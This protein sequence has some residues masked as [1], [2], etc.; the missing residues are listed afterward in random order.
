V[1]TVPGTGV[2]RTGNEEYLRLINALFCL[3][4]EAIS[5]AKIA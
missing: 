1:D 5:S 3:E 2:K 4:Q